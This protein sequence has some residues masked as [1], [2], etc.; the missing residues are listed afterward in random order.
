MQCE[1][2][3][4]PRLAC[5]SIPVSAV[6]YGFGLFSRPGAL[7]PKANDKRICHQCWH[8]RNISQKIAA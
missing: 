4:A 7:L 3:L 2:L 6:A 1:P 8:Q 5:G